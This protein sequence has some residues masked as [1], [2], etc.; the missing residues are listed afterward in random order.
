MHNG[1]AAKPS[2]SAHQYAILQMIA[3]GDSWAEINAHF[4]TKS[5]DANWQTLRRYRRHHNAETPAQAVAIAFARKDIETTLIVGGPAP[6]DEVTKRDIRMLMVGK[7]IKQIARVHGYN[8][9]KPMRKFL[10]KA[11]DAAGAKNDIN[12]M[13]L[14]MRNRWV[15]LPTDTGRLNPRIPVQITDMQRHVFRHLRDG[16]SVS[17]AIAELGISQPTWAHNLSK[18]KNAYG[19]RTLTQCVIH[20][21]DRRWI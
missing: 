3:D 11:G 4:P 7:T 20:A 10:K 15:A 17:E 9:D 21:H 19:L 16:G 8:T 12:L 18:Y 13:Y 14:A 1:S 6:F 2:G 5:R